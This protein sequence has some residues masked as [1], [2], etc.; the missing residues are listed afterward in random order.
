MLK[1][2][3][4]YL[5]FIFLLPFATQ[6]QSMV[7]P[8]LWASAAE[9][10]QITSNIMS[11]PWASSIYI[12]LKSRVDAKKDA[13]KLNPETILSTIPSLTGTDRTGHTEMLNTAAES[14]ILYY[15]TDNADYA[16]LAS[17]ILSNYT[18]KLA[19]VDT[20]NRRNAYFFGDWWLESRTV[21]PRIPII[22]DFVYN[23]VNNPAN[24]VYDLATH[25]RKKFNNTATQTTVKKLAANVLKSITASNCN[26]SL[27]AGNGALLNILMIDSDT[28]REGFFQRYYYDPSNK[29]PFDAFTWSLANFT[30]QNIWPETIS[31][32][33][34]SQEIVLQAMNIIDR[35][36]PELN[37]IT[38]NLRV[39]DGSYKYANFYY[40]SGASVRYGD[41][42]RNI[43][44]ITI[45]QRILAIAT[46]KNLTEYSNKAKQVLKFEYGLTNGYK[47]VVKTETLEWY[48]PLELL[49]GVNVANSVTPVAET[50]F[51]TVQIKHAGV[52][53]QRNNNTTDSINYGLMYFTGGASY[54]HAHSSGIEME[55]YGNGNVLGVNNG[56]GNYEAAIHDNYEIR[57]A[58]HN[59][60]IVNSSAKRGTLDQWA[61]VM[62]AVNLESCEPAPND[63]AISKD[64]AFSTQLLND[65]YNACR[66]QR[67]V[68]MIRTSNK[69]GYYLDVFRSKANGTNN[70]HD[71]LYHNIGDTVNLK[72][73]D[74]TVLPLTPSSRYTTDITNS[75]TGW[76]YFSNVISSAATS[77]AVKAI[78]PLNTVNKYM[79]AFMPSGVDREYST[80]VAPPT[81]EAENNY[82][83][84]NTPVM[85]IRQ[86]GEAWD[87][88]FICAYEP[89][90][91]NNPTIQSVEQLTSG[92]KVVG[93]KITSLVN[94]IRITD[95]IISHDG[96]NQ[97][98]SNNFDAISFV[99]RFGIVRTS[100]QDG[101][102]N[103]SMY[104]GDGSRLQFKDSVLVAN[105][106]KNGLKNFELIY[107][108]INDKVVSYLNIAPTMTSGNIT[109]N[110]GGNEQVKYAIYNTT[111]IYLKKGNAM[112][113]TQIDLSDFPNGTYFAQL[114]DNSRTVTQKFILKK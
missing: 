52:I 70:Y 84:K 106:K 22:Y 35:V 15:L 92:A 23:F 76:K 82:H 81:Y 26:H 8:I 14:A 47:P 94:G 28:V 6:S 13:H 113:N 78:F 56:T 30:T 75:V 49:W 45:Y 4:L 5:I 46:R 34:L 18:D 69:T 67:T 7:H 39:L 50:T 44:R 25:S 66:Q 95:W 55:L 89:S 1:K 24:T 61:R 37:I 103:V 20:T 102:T 43:N 32:S 114:I 62:D 9:K 91:G 54:V 17:D 38:N 2:T 109:I 3:I 65:N 108:G 104:I 58:A 85:T 64:F 101:N 10:S 72:Y 93:A 51:P 33:K 90:I 71:Y 63:V 60:V 48:G 87:R 77:N 40:P 74:N 110:A 88:P 53:I 86:Y 96:E 98:Y 73:L 105:L 83:K 59:T 21:Y 11:F 100:V 31:Y 80:A 79:H 12:Q 19:L 29:L 99:G 112:N 111:G 107:S 68:G 36:K 27:L 97:T 42:Q 16:Q 41:S 57:N